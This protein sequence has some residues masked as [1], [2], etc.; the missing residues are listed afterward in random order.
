MRDPDHEQLR[1]N[2]LLA[3][4]SGKRELEE[5]L[6]GKSTLNQVELAGRTAR[7]HKISYSTRPSTSCW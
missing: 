6:A 5:P 2:P 7:C 4:L 3:V 1:T